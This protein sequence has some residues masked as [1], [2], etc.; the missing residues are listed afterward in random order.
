MEVL[1]YIVYVHLPVTNIS[2]CTVVYIHCIHVA[3]QHGVTYA[4]YSHTQTQTHR[5]K[6]ICIAEN[7]LNNDCCL[8]G[9]IDYRFDRKELR[10]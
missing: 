10:P 8:V 2:H 6:H 9:Y 5:H 3:K 1:H 7:S 4:A